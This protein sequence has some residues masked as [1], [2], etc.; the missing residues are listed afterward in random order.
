MLFLRGVAMTSSRKRLGNRLIF[1][2]G[3]IY[4]GETSNIE[5][6]NTKAA[7]ISKRI[8][9]PHI[10]K[11]INISFSV[12]VY[13]GKYSFNFENFFYHTSDFRKNE[14]PIHCSFMFW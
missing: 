12:Y 5:A 1:E 14:R 10:L 13:L 7:W 8:N 11:K 4:Y 6:E 3:L 2:A 9:T